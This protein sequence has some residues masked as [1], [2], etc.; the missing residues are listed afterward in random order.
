MG[1]DM[2]LVSNECPV[3]ALK[4]RPVPEVRVLTF[5]SDGEPVCKPFSTWGLVVLK[6]WCDDKR[7]WVRVVENNVY[8]HAKCG[9]TVSVVV[10]V[11]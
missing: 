5:E 8:F 10:T 2:D 7:G 6:A 11:L 9:A 4:R 1:F 3:Y